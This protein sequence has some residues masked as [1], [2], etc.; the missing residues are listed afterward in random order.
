[1]KFPLNTDPVVGDFFGKCKDV[2]IYRCIKIHVLLFTK[3]ANENTE[4]I[5]RSLYKF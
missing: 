3:V 1:M 2:L 4:S 5:S